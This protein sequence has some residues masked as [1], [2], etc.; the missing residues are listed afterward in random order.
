M[1]A[2]IIE[3]NAISK[4]YLPIFN[5]VRYFTDTQNQPP[6]VLYRKWCRPATLLKKEA[7]AQGFSCEFCEISKNTFLTRYLWTTASGSN[8]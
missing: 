3:L 7:L 8:L 5:L 4:D 2:L 6:E 1:L